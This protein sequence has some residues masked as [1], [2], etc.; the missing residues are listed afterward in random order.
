MPTVP[1]SLFLSFNLSLSLSILPP[2]F[3]ISLWL[4]G[5]ALSQA[6][7]PS[8]LGLSFLVA[9][10]GREECPPP[11]LVMLSREGNAEGGGCLW[12]PL[13]DFCHCGK[14]LGFM[15]TPLAAHSQ[16]LRKVEPRPCGAELHAR[17]FLLLSH[18]P[19]MLPPCSASF[20]HTYEMLRSLGH[21]TQTFLL[22]LSWWL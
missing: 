13:K 5:R 2:P 15:S 6:R 14:P 8:P 16:S 4:P 3:S 17:S 20:S 9:Q 7:L 22:R 18:N 11:R 12:S 10:C 19:G 1:S 21:M